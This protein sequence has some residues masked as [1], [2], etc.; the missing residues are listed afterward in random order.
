MMLPLMQATQERLMLMELYVQLDVELAYYD[1]AIAEV[2]QRN[3]RDKNK[4]GK[5]RREYGQ[6]NGY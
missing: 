4:E 1:L 5:R 6:G 2:I 3:H